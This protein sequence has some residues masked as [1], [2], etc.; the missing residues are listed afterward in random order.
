M[1]AP[2]TSPQVAHRLSIV[3]YGLPAPQGSKRFVGRG[4][5]IDDNPVALRTWR[6]DVKHAA[7]E[8]MAGTPGWFRD[9]RA[10]VGH[11]AFTLPR[12]AAHYLP[13]APRLKRPAG[14]LREDAP[15][16]H[17]SRPD[18]DKLLRSTWDALTTA[19]AYVDDARLCQVHALKHYTSSE[20]EALALDRPGVRIVLVGIGR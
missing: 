7:L 10:V 12:P 2:P 9:Y 6:E 1:T 15:T 19:G 11:F 20:P 3:A 4:I 16:V 8:A 17:A 18:L 13:A 14:Q 5:L